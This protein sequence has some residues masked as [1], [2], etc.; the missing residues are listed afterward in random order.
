MVGLSDYSAQNWLNYLTGRSAMPATPTAW[1]ALF[2]A[3]GADNNTGFTEISGNGYARV[4]T[5]GKWTAGAGGSGPITISNSATLAFPISTASWPLAIAWGLFDASGGGNLLCWDWLGSN[6]WWPYTATSAS[7]SVITAKGITQGSPTA[8][9]NSSPV[10]IDEEFGGSLPTGIGANTQYTVAGLS[11]DVFNI[12][13]NTTSTGAGMINPIVPVTIGSGVIFSFP[14]GSLVLASGPINGFINT[15]SQSVIVIDSRYQ[16]PAKT[17]TDSA[18]VIWRTNPA[19]QVMFNG[20]IDANTSQ[21]VKMA[22][23]GSNVWYLNYAGTWYFKSVTASPS[24]GGWTTGSNPLPAGQ[25][26]RIHDLVATFGV[27]ILPVYNQAGGA[28]IVSSAIHLSS[29]QYLGFTM[30][31]VQCSQGSGSSSPTA[32]QTLYLT[33]HGVRGHFIVGQQ[34][35]SDGSNFASWIAAQISDTGIASIFGF[36][37]TNEP[38]NNGLSAAQV[39]SLCSSLG[40]AVAG[41][42]NTNNVVPAISFSPG[43]QGGTTAT[44]FVTAVGDQTS[45]GIHWGTWHGYTQN[46]SNLCVQPWANPNGA[47][48]A[49][50]WTRVQCPGR[51]YTL[52][53]F[54]VLIPG[55]T[56]SYEQ[57]TAAAGGKMML[58]NYLD[59]YYNGAA[60]VFQ[61]ELFDETAET[62]ALFDPSGNPYPCATV[63]HNFTTI[64][65][66]AGGTA[67]SFN[68]SAL[69]YSISGLPTSGTYWG[70]SMLFQSS[71]LA[72]ILIIWNEPEVQSGPP[73]TNTTPTTTT[74]TITINQAFSS[75][76]LYDPTVG[77]SSVQNFGAITSGQQITVGLVGYAKIVILTP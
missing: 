37:V 22:L 43:Y 31:R 10:V 56:S 6:S 62:F 44:S 41:N 45:R 52:G 58:N 61:F 18:G 65:A 11:N 27:N 7:P 67:S 2:S 50:T 68:P 23:V 20:T 36:E 70:R 14:A 66:D 38:N 21:V 57:A 1:L 53:E 60:G 69:N 4:N 49:N 46:G 73:A 9:A 3:V 47:Q 16:N 75:A 63:F 8:F 40:S 19:C 74:V 54:G 39:Q 55:S 71:N 30:V 35:S 29:I 26:I 24:S 76:N 15:A 42:S 33:Q 51:P 5:S 64:I 12:G 32:A 13:V 28:G 25:A 77:T 72:F 48:D 34:G 17:M 59:A